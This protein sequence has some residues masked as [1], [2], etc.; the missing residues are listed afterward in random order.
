[1]QLLNVVSSI[2]TIFT[3][4]VTFGVVDIQTENIVFNWGVAERVLLFSILMLSVLSTISNFV[5]YFSKLEPMK[6]I[7]PVCILAIINAYVVMKLAHAII[8][9]T[10]TDWYQLLVSFGIL[11]VAI[12]YS[13]LQISGKLSDDFWFSNRGKYASPVNYIFNGAMFIM[14]S[15][16]YSATYS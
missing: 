6:F 7:T 2:I 5:L 10:L 16:T 12:T 13:S 1:M 4:I 11:F 8:L 3:F 9:S 15:A 14:Y